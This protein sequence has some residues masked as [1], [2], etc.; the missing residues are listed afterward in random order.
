MY[1]KFAIFDDCAIYIDEEEGFVKLVKN[2]KGLEAANLENGIKSLKKE[3]N[4]DKKKAMLFK[5][6][7]ILK[8]IKNLESHL[9]FFEER[10]MEEESKL[11]SD[12]ATLQDISRITDEINKE[13]VKKL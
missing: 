7:K 5:S 9:N 2:N 1:N 8:C 12:Y 11:D 13:K 6:K 10:F 4:R 3:I